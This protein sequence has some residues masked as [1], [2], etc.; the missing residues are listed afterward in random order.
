M[1][2]SSTK[3]ELS[4]KTSYQESDLITN[5]TDLRSFRSVIITKTKILMQR[6]ENSSRLERASIS[7]HTEWISYIKNL[8]NV[9]KISISRKIISAYNSQDSHI[10]M[11]DFSDASES[12]YGACIYL[13]SFT[14]K[15]I[16]EVHLVCSK[17]RVGVGSIEVVIDIEIGALRCTIVMQLASSRYLEFSLFHIYLIQESDFLLMNPAFYQADLYCW[18]LICVV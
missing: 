2:H 12:A 9:E 11:Y 10:E 13:R 7:R 8:Q 6:L 3:F 15:G 4:S 16:P 17:S 18:M 14:S 5:R 1:I